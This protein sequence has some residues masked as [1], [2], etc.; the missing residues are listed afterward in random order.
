MNREKPAKTLWEEIMPD[1][2]QLWI[3]AEQPMTY[4]DDSRL[5]RWHLWITPLG[6]C[7]V[8]CLLYLSLLDTHW[9]V[10]CPT[11]KK[12]LMWEGH[13]GLRSRCHCVNNFLS[14][15][16]PTIFAAYQILCYLSCY[17]LQLLALRCYGMQ[18]HLEI[19]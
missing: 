18:R 9:L 12:R 13:K 8:G 15:G 19:K 14:V 17:D 16:I 7:V 10:R 11:G 6:G 3:I 2:T 5:R 1:L 4:F